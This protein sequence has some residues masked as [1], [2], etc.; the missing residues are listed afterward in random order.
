MFEV[1][2]VLA[3]YWIARQNNRLKHRFNQRVEVI[4]RR[5]YNDGHTAGYKRGHTEGARESYDLGYDN[6][7]AEAI[8]AGG[9]IL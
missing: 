5:G 2:V 8:K 3:L 4:R 9:Y 6:A 7:A 1:I